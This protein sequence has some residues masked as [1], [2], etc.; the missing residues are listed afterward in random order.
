MKRRGHSSIKVTLD[1]YGHMFPS[2]D[3]AF[4]QG[5]EEQFREAVSTRSRPTRGLSKLPLSA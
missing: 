2:L 1:T 4:T 3:E 5:L